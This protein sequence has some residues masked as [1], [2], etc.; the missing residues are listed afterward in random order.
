MK[1][2]ELHERL[3]LVTWRRID[4]GVLSSSLLA[5]QTGLAQAHISNFLHRRR[6]LSLP[7]LDRILQ[8]Q[9]LSV[10]DLSPNGVPTHA[11]P[12]SLPAE[13]RDVVP[14]VSQNAAVTAPVISPRAIVDSVQLPFGWLASFPVRRAVS[15]RSWERFVAV[16]VTHAQAFSMDPVLHADSMVVLDRHYNSLAPLRP[17]RPNL[18]GVRLGTQLLFRHVV[19]ESSRLILRPR[20]LEAPL[21]VIE[22]GPQESPSDLIVGR[23]CLCISQL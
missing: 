22:L 9:A 14:L 19:F 5:R 18:Y 21:D 3:R 10:E 16:R 6:R 13:T 7:A 23:V 2:L 12:G 4:Q 15:R 1:F 17:P 20:A 11:M 8:A